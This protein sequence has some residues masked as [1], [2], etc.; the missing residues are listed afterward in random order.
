MLTVRSEIEPY[1]KPPRDFTEK[2]YKWCKPRL[3][4]TA[5]LQVKNQHKGFDQEQFFK[6]FC[7]DVA[8]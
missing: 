2:P 6:W 1:E 8:P 4:G 3:R 5:V 7:A